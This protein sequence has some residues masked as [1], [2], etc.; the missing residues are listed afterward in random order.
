MKQSLELAVT[1][2]Q[3]FGNYR[4]I[5]MLVRPHAPVDTITYE[6]ETVIRAIDRWHETPFITKI[7][8]CTIIEAGCKQ[9]LRIRQIYKKVDYSEMVA[10]CPTALSLTESTDVTTTQRIEDKRQLGLTGRQPGNERI[11]RCGLFA[12]QTLE[13]LPNGINSN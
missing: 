8:A 10:S 6:R 7:G 9:A 12:G 2:Q 5:F 11:Y 13:F 4:E 3:S 1:G